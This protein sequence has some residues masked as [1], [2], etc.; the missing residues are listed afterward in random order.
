MLL[1]RRQNGGRKTNPWTIFVQYVRDGICC[2]VYLSAFQGGC[3]F[4]YIRGY[5]ILPLLR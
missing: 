2:V 4:V 1:Y 3:V 5:S